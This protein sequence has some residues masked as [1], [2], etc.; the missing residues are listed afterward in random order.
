MVPILPVDRAVGGVAILAVLLAIGGP[1]LVWLPAVCHAKNP[2]KGTGH[3]L[4]L[5]QNVEG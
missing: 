1:V 5:M 4:D 2:G 3:L